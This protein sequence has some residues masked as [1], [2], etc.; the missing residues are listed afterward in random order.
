[1][2]GGRTHLYQPTLFD[3]FKSSIKKVTNTTGDHKTLINSF[4]DNF[5]RKQTSSFT[6]QRCLR[7]ALGV[8]LLFEYLQARAV[9]PQREI[10]PQKC[11]DLN[12]SDLPFSR[13]KDEI[14]CVS[15]LNDNVLL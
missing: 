2:Q 8:F 11:F 9:T 13:L 5:H 6:M 14:K 7:I 3:T 15:I 10:S 12:D 4:S 1:M